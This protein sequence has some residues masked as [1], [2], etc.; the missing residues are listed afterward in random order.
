LRDGNRGLVVRC[1]AGCQTREVFAELRRRGLIAGRF[2]D[3]RAAPAAPSNDGANAARRTAL[4]RR[5]WNAAKDARGSPV[6]SYFAA[7]GITIP[8]PPSLRWAPTLRRPDGSHGPAMVARVDGLDG[9]LIGVHRTYF[10]RNADGVWR[11]RDRASLGPVGGGAVRLAPAAKE[12]LT[13]EGVETTLA[14]MVATGLPSWA[15]LSTTGLKALL[16]PRDV[17]SVIIC[18]DNDDNG[19]GEQA[20]RAAARRWLAEGRR[21]RIALPPERDT[22]FADLLTGRAYARKMGLS[23]AAA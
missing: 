22:D 14:G 5:I 13:G 15:A 23:D 8:L 18:A 3:A 4:A 21:V 6:V 12:L 19:A 20:A 2:G 16:L 10:D 7:R 17:R 1:W 11:R 9:G